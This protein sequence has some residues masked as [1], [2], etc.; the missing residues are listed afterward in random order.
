MGD[1]LRREPVRSL[2]TDTDLRSRPP[3]LQALVV[4][5]PPAGQPY[6]SAVRD[7]VDHA[8]RLGA[9]IMPVAMEAANAAPPEPLEERRAFDVDDVL[10]R[11][12][13]PASAFDTAGDE[14]ARRL[15][16]KLW[17]TCAPERLQLF[18]SYRTAESSRLTRALAQALDNLQESPILDVDQL[19][20]GV[21][22]RSEIEAKLRTCDVLVFLDTPAVARSDWVRW[23]L[24]TA[25]A[26]AVPIV[27]VELGG[28]TPREDLAVWPSDRPDL[29]YEVLDDP[30]R[31]MEI[32]VEI[33]DRAFEVALA[34]VRRACRTIDRIRRIEPLSL[35]D[36]DRR[37]QIYC[38]SRARSFRGR[39][40]APEQ[41]VIQ[42]FG[43]RTSD[44]DRSRFTTWF[45][46]DR[47]T[48]AAGLAMNGF[49]LSSTP[50]P[51]DE[52]DA[53]ITTDGIAYI[54]EQAGTVATATSVGPELLLLGAFPRNEGASQEIRD[55]V[56]ELATT[57]LS[58]GGRLRFGGHPT[59]TPLVNLAAEATLGAAA[60]T[61]VT[62]YQSAWFPSVGTRTEIEA[63]ATVVVTEA[64]ADRDESLTIM[65]QRMIADGTIAAAVAVG[66]RTMEGGTHAPGVEEEVGL[67]RA[68]GIAVY[69]LGRP[70]GH[71]MAMAES[72]QQSD[73]PWSDLGNKMSPNE[74]EALMTTDDYW[75]VGRTLW[76][77]HTS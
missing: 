28:G 63:L 53:V 25:M 4:F 23:E 77:R 74:N 18:L 52:D 14:L 7:L 24:A 39:P 42:V 71:T 36:V 27:W 73:P 29:R 5:N 65:R 9:V 58:R 75:N 44:A 11:R 43:R 22:I 13:L 56:H 10:R 46:G 60:A 50:M 20:S 19:R 3:D 15:V 1:K 2:T 61:H 17:P 47:A 62:M 64:G 33:R 55:A 38:V 67:A 34:H 32:A 69:L 6:Q 68:Q 26:M 30:D 35:S 37:Q 51:P 16:A 45:H 41:H 59:I 49:L 21:A 66:G 48:T 57:W 70:G 40:I 76:E 72:A 12:D 8:L 31:A 54:E